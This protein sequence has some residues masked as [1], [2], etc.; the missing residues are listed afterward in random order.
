MDSDGLTQELSKG[1]QAWILSTKCLPFDCSRNRHL[2]KRSQKAGL[3]SESPT[4]TLKPHEPCFL[5]PWSPLR[6]MAGR[7]GCISGGGETCW[8]S[9]PGDGL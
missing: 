7:Q 1:A 3:D 4:A 2:G 8:E 6:P 5:F 9:Y